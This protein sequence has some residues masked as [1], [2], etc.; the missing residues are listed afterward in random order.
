MREIHELYKKYMR[1]LLQNASSAPELWT[2]HCPERLIFQELIVSSGKKSLFLFIYVLK[3]V[4][5][6]S[7]Q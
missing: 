5:N 7:I 1:P 4:L 3:F 2:V 6:F